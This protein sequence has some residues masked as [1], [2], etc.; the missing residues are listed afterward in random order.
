MKKHIELDYRGEILRGYLDRPHSSGMHPLVIMYHGF[1][2]DCTEKNFLLTRLAKELAGQGIASLRMSFRGS[3][4]SDGDFIDTACLDQAAQAKAILRYAQA[5]PGID[6]GRIALLGMSMG[7][8]AALLAARDHQADLKGLILLAPAFRYAEKYRHCF[9][10]TGICWH[11]NLPV[12]RRFLEEA[13]PETFRAALED[14]ALPVHFFHG[15]LDTSVP[16]VVSLEFREHARAGSLTLIEGTDH[17]FNTP[18]GF[19]QLA[20]G[21]TKT[22]ARLLAQ[23]DPRS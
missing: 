15:T 17:G 23:E 18:A 4:E 8:C 11:G 16:P 9:D 6:G 20:E 5:I 1:T 12:S 2:G 13:D 10:E 14:L 19:R 22:A 21:V 3:G 7:S